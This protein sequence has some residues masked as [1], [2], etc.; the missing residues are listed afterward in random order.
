MKFTL[1]FKSPE[2]LLCEFKAGR[3]RR[4]LGLGKFVNVNAVT[5][6]LFSGG[7]GGFGASIEPIDLS[8]LNAPIG[9]PDRPLTE[10][11]FARMAPWDQR[12][13]P[14]SLSQLA[15]D[16]LSSTRL[17][18][19][20]LGTGPGSSVRDKNDKALFII[21]N[22]VRKLQALAD[23]AAQDNVSSAT[24]AQLQA[25]ITKGIA[26]VTAHARGTELE[27]ALLLPGR[28]AANF[29]TDIANNSAGQYDSKVLVTG[30]EGAVPPGFEGDRRFNLTITKGGV[31]TTLLIDLAGMGETSRTAFEVTNYINTIIRDQAF[32]TRLSAVVTKLAPPAGASSAVSTALARFEHRMRIKIGAGESI[33]L[34]PVAGDTE[35]ALFVA[36][37]KVVN[38][39]TQSVVTKT[40]DL[41]AAESVPAFEKDLAASG[42]GTA[43]AKAMARGPDGSMFV[44]ADATSR[45]NGITPKA[46]SDVLLMKYDTSGQ[47]VWSRALGSA[48]PAE[49]FSIAVGANGTIAV[50][51]A[52]DGRADKAITTVGEGRDSFVATFDSEGRDLW[53][54][55]QGALGTDSATH[56]AVSDDGQVYVTGQTVESYGDSAT[57]GGTDTYLQAF[58]AFGAVKYTTTIGTSGDDTPSG[59][60]LRNGAPTVVWNQPNGPRIGQFDADTGASGA[61]SDLLAQTG[62]SGI[63]SVTTDETGRMFFVGRV[64]DSTQNDQLVGFDPTTSNVLFQIQAPGAIRS[65][66]AAGGQVA[67]IANANV[68]VPASDTGPATVTRQPRMFGLSADTGTQIFNRAAPTTL[69]G[70]VVMSL[71]ASASKTLDG[72]G[73]PEGN[74]T[75]GDTSKLT[76][77]TALRAGDHFFISVNGRSDRKVE[78]EQGET[79]RT[80]A[81][82]M[83]RVLLRDGRT[84]VRSVAGNE[85]LTITPNADDR[86][87]LKAGASVT[88]ALKQLGL[89]PSVAIAKPATAGTRSVSDAAPVISLEI[90]LTGDVSSKAVAKATADSF[91]GVLRRIRIGYREISTD[92]TQVALRK[93]IADGKKKSTSSAGAIAYYNAQAAAGQDALRKFGISV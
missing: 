66:T 7:G 30:A 75:F 37:S 45:T 12:V 60:M 57:L 88:D 46:A 25:R 86:I 93:Q 44:I 82:K 50:V 72:L 31:P 33:Q 78:I 54:H 53:Y 19:T 79:L 9:G 3:P 80:L 77:R 58:D 55:Q 27:G 71:T 69:T 91:D 59:L 62:L 15:R 16:A 23:A 20:S 67:Y 61:S 64:G 38:G 35:P 51:G 13:R 63:S 56:V 14:P 92:P 10:R 36:G 28:R 32:E 65:V 52:V 4:V 21:H 89:E 34:T 70:S 5:L 24:R 42:S 49:G 39:R 81:A 43:R 83:N 74:L 68:T 90:P 76:D 8:V 47:V 29:V 2:S 6:G 73:L 40:M 1:V 85:T 87:E 41:S 48:A 84:E 11:D 22:G 18:D 17:I 26:E